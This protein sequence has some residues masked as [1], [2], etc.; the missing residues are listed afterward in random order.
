MRKALS[1]LLTFIFLFNIAGYYLWFAVQQKKI[2]ED[3]EQQIRKGLSS[4][5]LS[6]VIV[7]LNG[8]NQLKWI[9]PAKEFRLN[10]EMYDVVRSKTNGQ[11]KYY[12]CIIDNKEKKLIANFHR[13]HTSKKEADKRNKNTLNDRFIPKNYFIINTNYPVNIDYQQLTIALVS[14]ILKIP[15]PPPK[16]I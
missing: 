12:Y 7:P 6:V 14:N 11:N 5:D 9:K 2:K 16:T 1:I 13:T 10:G 15:S 4:E 3:V 8:Q